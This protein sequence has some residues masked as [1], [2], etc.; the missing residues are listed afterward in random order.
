MRKGAERGLACAG[1]TGLFDV[2]IGCDDVVEPKPAA[3][4]AILALTRLDHAAKHALMVGDSPH[5]IDCGKR[6]GT[7]TA[8]VLWGPFSRNSFG[9]IQPDRWLEHPREFA[10]LS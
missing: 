8:A 3:E 5:D 7:R 9:A 6:A 4:P 1:F 10:F 2:V